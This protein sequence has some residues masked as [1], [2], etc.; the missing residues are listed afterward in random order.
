MKNQYIKVLS[1][2]V[3]LLVFSF[4]Q[5]I[6]LRQFDI[7][8]YVLEVGF[9]YVL[10]NSLIKTNKSES[11]L[12]KDFIL[13][14]V[15]VAL[16][17][18]SVTYVLG[19]F[20]GFIKTSYSTSL[21]GIL[22]NLIIS[23]IFIILLENIR[24]IIIKQGRYYKSLVFLSLIVITCLEL[25]FTIS[26]VQFSDKRTI[27]E[28]IMVIVIP[29]LFRN[30]FLTYSTY[31]FSKRGSLVYHLIMVEVSYVVPVF[32]NFGD[33]I[34]VILAVM[35]P[36]ITLVAS[37]N[38]IFTKSDLIDDSKSYLKRLKY[39]KI[40]FAII[41]VFLLIMVYLVSGFGRY[42][43]LAIGSESM[44]GTIDKGDVVFIDKKDNNYN[45]GDIIVFEKE[46]LLLVHRIVDINKGERTSYVTKG[47]FNNAQDDFLVYNSSIK[48]KTKFKIKY[49]GW[50]TVLLTEYLNR[51]E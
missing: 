24:D 37:S 19:F 35:V 13:I 30:I 41:L 16:I 44:K 6:F 43:V 40:S 12:N 3:F 27:L 17:Y 8:L 48:G 21:M 28:I 22:K 49:L 34:N 36:I 50:P 4:L 9:I 33:Y 38:I 32:P 2:E 5:F 18:Y 15:A 11:H 31:Y 23:T 29:C 45:I 46:G 1:I 10:L 39:E 51:K 25:L 20:V 7:T 42:S 47:D 14:I 26:L